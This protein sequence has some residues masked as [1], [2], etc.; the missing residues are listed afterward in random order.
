[1]E[2]HVLRQNVWIYHLEVTISCI[3]DSLNHR[4]DLHPTENGVLNHL[5]DTE[6]VV[7]VPTRRIVC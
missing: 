1:M 4:C 7:Q 5:L 2:E 3:D 6:F